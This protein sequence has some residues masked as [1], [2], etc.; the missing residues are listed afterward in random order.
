VRARGPLST[1]FLP[2]RPSPPQVIWAPALLGERLSARHY[3]ATAL[4]LV[5]VAAAVAAG[6]RSD[7]HLAL[8]ALL[9]RFETT[10]FGGYVAVVAA[11]VAALWAGV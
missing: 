1:V 5:G 8:P 2:S 3:V 7:A 9:A 6:P 4:I 10:G 11:A